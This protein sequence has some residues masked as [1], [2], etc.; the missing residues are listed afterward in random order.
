MLLFQKSIATERQRDIS[1]DDVTP[2]D[3]DQGGALTNSSLIGPLKTIDN[4]VNGI[5]ET[6]KQSNKADAKAQNDARKTSRERCKS[7]KEGKLEGIK[8]KLADAAQTVLKPVKNIFQK[9]WDFLKIVLLGKSCNETF[10]WFTDDENKEKVASYIQIFKGLVAV[11]VAGIMA[12]VGPGMDFT[13]GLI[14]LL[15]WGIPKIIEAVKWV[16]SLFGIGVDKE[17]K[18]IEDECCQIWVKI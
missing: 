4:G 1:A 2:Q 7:K 9:I 18:N 3:A 17:L 16:G 12:I 8:G 13:A 6:L 10:E 15:A 11:L 5:I 14:A